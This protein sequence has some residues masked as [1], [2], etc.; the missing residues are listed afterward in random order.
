MQGSSALAGEAQPGTTRPHG[1]ARRIT[2]AVVAAAA[3]VVGIVVVGATRLDD[4]AQIQVSDAGFD[5]PVTSRSSSTT[6]TTT[7]PVSTVAPQTAAVA[8]PTTVGVVTPLPTRA[9][10]PPAPTNPTTQTTAT[11]TTAAPAPVVRFTI[12]PATVAWTPSGFPRPTLL[13]SVGSAP[14][15][16]VLGPAVNATTLQGSQPVCP[17]AVNAGGFCTAG[18]GAYTYVLQVKDASG[19]VID[20]R[21]VTLTVR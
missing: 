4:S 16:T 21:T 7:A 15:A 19:Q 8:P 5:V 3:V 18:R 14:A 6:T 13:W 17:T 10:D 2:L 12:T 11:T 1:R 9:T 20:Q